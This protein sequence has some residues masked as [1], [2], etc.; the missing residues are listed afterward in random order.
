MNDLIDAVEG[1]IGL[2][3]GGLILLLFGSAL[4]ATGPIDLSFWGIVYILVGALALIV[5]VAAA[6]GAVISEVV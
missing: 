3:C 6:A 1:A 4:G 2:L 5:A